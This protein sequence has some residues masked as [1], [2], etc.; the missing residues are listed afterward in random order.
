MA[1][2]AISRLPAIVRSTAFA[3]VGTVD[4]VDVACSGSFDS[5]SFLFALLLFWVF[6]KEGGGVAIS[7]L[8]AIVRSTAF[9]REGTAGPVDAACLGC[10]FIWSLFLLF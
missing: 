3:R 5:C 4:P 7:P 6:L 2:A 1:V 8:P 10:L 9:A